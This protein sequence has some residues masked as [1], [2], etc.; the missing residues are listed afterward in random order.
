M[1]QSN[2]EDVRIKLSLLPHAETFLF[3][4]EV[5]YYFHRFGRSFC[6]YLLWKGNEN[7][8][9][10]ESDMKVNMD[11][12]EGT[13]VTRLNFEEKPEFL[14]NFNGAQHCIPRTSSTRSLL[15]VVP[16]LL[17]CKIGV[18]PNILWLNM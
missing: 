9:L 10:T 2:T 11:N 4:P 17:K 5:I 15:Q 14:S 1:R 18:S 7:E 13:T 12:I 16:Y 6:F 3:A 8:A